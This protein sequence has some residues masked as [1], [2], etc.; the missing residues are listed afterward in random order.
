MTDV[1]ENIN[2][3]RV[4][5]LSVITSVFHNDPCFD[6]FRVKT[7]ILGNI[8]STEIYADIKYY[9]NVCTL[10]FIF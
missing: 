6:F 4:D 5:R 2:L 9:S 3:W 8:P 7:R 10:Y 1:K